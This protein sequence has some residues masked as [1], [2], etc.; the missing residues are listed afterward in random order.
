MPRI[1]LLILIAVAIAVIGQISLKIGMTQIGEIRTFFSLNFLIKIITNPLIIFALFLYALGFV[2]W[3][4]ILSKAY[5][6][7]DLLS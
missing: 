4:G 1:I 6:N 5:L 7:S 3:A 2:L